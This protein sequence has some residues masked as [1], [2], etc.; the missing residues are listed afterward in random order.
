MVK[1][2]QFAGT[3]NGKIFNVEARQSIGR[4]FGPIYLD[5]EEYYTSGQNVHI[6]MTS[7]LELPVPV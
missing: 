4:T 1:D 2:C 5:A 6:L 7:R 3:I